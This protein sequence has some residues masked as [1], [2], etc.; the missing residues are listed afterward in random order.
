MKFPCLQL[1]LLVASSLLARAA[2]TLP[3]I[4]S[5]H[6]VLQQSSRVPIWGAADPGEE[7][8]VEFAGQS[9]TTIAGVDGKWQIALNPLKVGAPQ[10]LTIRGKQTLTIQDVLVGEV[11]LGSGQSNMAMTVA[12]SKDFDTEKTTRTFR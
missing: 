3:A 5:D 12:R 9:H 4:L 6:A 8:T 7:I 1:G 10:T 2:V 11:W